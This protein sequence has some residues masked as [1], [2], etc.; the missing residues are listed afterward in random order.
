[1][2][3][4]T[5]AALALLTAC[6]F[7]PVDL[8]AALDTCEQPPPEI[9]FT[10]PDGEELFSREWVR[11]DPRSAHGDGLGPL[12]NATSCVACHN[13]AGI[14]GGGGKSANV[15]L[16]PTQGVLHKVGRQP[17]G[18]RLGTTAG[19][20]LRGFGFQS[21]PER[22][23]PALFGMGV[24]DTVTESDMLVAAAVANIDHPEVS[25]RI[26]RDEDG[27]P[28]RFG[29]KAQLSTLD[30][31]V[32]AA[33]SNELGLET[34]E[35]PQPMARDKDVAPGLDLVSADV[36]ALSDFVA[37]IPQPMRASHPLAKLGEQRFG[38]VGCA[39]CH[40]E[41]LGDAEAVYSDLLLHDLGP[42]LSD[43]A[44]SYG[45]AR[46]ASTSVADSEAATAEEWRTPPLWGVRD[47]APYLHDGRA[48]TLESAIGMHRG[49][50]TEIRTAYYAMSPEDQEAVIAFLKT[51]V[52]PTT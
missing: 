7:E 46:R 4:I 36:D 9:A 10:A 42:G 13:Q 25:G 12:Y 22:N 44:S 6:D 39:A 50:A 26:A 29:W 16:H 20:G 2:H 48:N 24:L 47:S 41:N 18:L 38:E 17:Q 1:M 33:C 51:L 40:A 23:T 28:G 35:V 8:D 30:D 43:N 5:F 32:V 52:A 14:G 11:N 3:K 49:E 19:F 27:K 15:I 31:F 34:P 45:M 37:G 21:R